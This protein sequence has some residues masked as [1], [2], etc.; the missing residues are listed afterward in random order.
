M[1][2]ND[3]KNNC[4]SEFNE[5]YFMKNIKNVINNEF[6]NKK[7]EI[8]EEKMKKNNSH[9]LN[10]IYKEKLF[11]FFNV[12]DQKEYDES[13]NDIFLFFDENI[14]NIFEI[15][16][17]FDGIIEVINYNYNTIINNFFLEKCINSIYDWCVLFSVKKINLSNKTSA[18]LTILYFFYVFFPNDVKKIFKQFIFLNVFDI[19]LIKKNELVEYFNKKE[20]I[21][22]TISST[23]YILKI[24][25]FEIEDIEGFLKYMSKKIVDNLNDIN[26][27]NKKYYFHMNGDYCDGAL[28][29]FIENI[30]NIIDYE[31]TYNLESSE[32]PILSRKINDDLYKNKK[33]LNS[34][35]NVIE[36]LVHFQKGQK[37]KKTIKQEKLLT[38]PEIINENNKK[39]INDS[40]T[41]NLIN[42]M[43]HENNRKMSDEKSS[44]SFSD[45][46][47]I[48]LIEKKLKKILEKKKSKMNETDIENIN[49]E[50]NKINK[51]LINNNFH[52]FSE[53]KNKKKELEKK[54]DIFLKNKKYEERNK[55]KEW[56]NDTIHYD[57]IFGSKRIQY[58]IEKKNDDSIN[59]NNKSKKRHREEDYEII[60][61]LKNKKSKKI[62]TKNIKQK[63]NKKCKTK[64]TKKNKK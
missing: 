37:L 64:K 32:I 59:L 43:N 24:S 35:N 12:T 42:V 63:K 28:S 48:Y 60:G 61:G 19:F 30:G 9:F 34:F 38:L 25:G 45:D 23:F 47:N 31:T 4:Y 56:N 29:F 20:V 50:I 1:E 33:I 52:N 54:L 8:E 53:L 16:D 58:N 18:I 17:I 49:I 21:S 2:K 39:I 3:Y 11:I 7:Y 44:M 13:Q 22:A 27:K 62:K 46:S 36:E 5:C 15:E 14:N 26:F 55:F 6:L 10:E 57:N 51:M 41:K 40:I